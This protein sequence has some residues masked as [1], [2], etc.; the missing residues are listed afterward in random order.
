ML[1]KIKTNYIHLLAPLGLFFVI[2][3]FIF[4]SQPTFQIE[5][6]VL[7]ALLYLISALVHH[8]F[9]KS[10]TLETTIEYILLAVLVIIMVTGVIL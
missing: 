3:S 4:K 2:L 10:L 5:I 6:L 9:D 8:H 7:F 1:K